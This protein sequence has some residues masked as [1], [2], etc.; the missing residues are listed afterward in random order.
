[1]DT[2]EIFKDKFFVDLQRELESKQEYLASI[3]NPNEY[4][5]VKTELE[6]LQN[7]I[8]SYVRYLEDKYNVKEEVSA[9][10]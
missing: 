3:L 8:D 2:L 9:N 5:A 4:L 10:K 6:L 1:M 7:I